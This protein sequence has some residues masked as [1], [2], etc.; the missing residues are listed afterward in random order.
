MRPSA[1]EEITEH[2][3]AKVFEDFD[4]HC[5]RLQSPLNSPPL[6]HRFSSAREAWSFWFAYFDQKTGELKEELPL[7]D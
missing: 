7:P 2:G 5:F 6:P 1:W 3:T 4:N